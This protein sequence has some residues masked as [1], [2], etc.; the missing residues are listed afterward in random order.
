MSEEETDGRFAAGQFYR[1]LRV[2]GGPR[3]IDVRNKA[4][5]VRTPEDEHFERLVRLGLAG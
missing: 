4:I 3:H 2:L 5:R 1:L